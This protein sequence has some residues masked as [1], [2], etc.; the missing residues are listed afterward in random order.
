MSVHVS[1]NVFM[2]LTPKRS[3]GDFRCDQQEYSSPRE[4]CVSDQGPQSGDRSTGT[5]GAKKSC[6]RLMKQLV[7]GGRNL[8]EVH[9]WIGTNRTVAYCRDSDAPLFDFAVKSPG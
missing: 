4:V 8:A 3:G 9:G 2:S 5:Q 1:A 6:E 7:G